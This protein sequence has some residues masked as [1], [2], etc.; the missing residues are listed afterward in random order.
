MSKRHRKCS[1]QKEI[2]LLTAIRFF[3][4]ADAIGVTSLRGQPEKTRGAVLEFLR[5]IDLSDVP[6]SAPAFTCW[7]NDRTECLR[8]RIWRRV[9]RE[10]RD[11]LKDK[12]P[13]PSM[14]MWGVA[15]KS[16]NLFLRC[17]LYNHY[18]RSKHH[19]ERIEPLLE[20]PLDSVVGKGLRRAQSLLE[21]HHSKKAKLLRSLLGLPRMVGKSHRDQSG[22]SGLPLWRH[23]QV[24]DGRDSERFQRYAASLAKKMRLP[25]PVFLDN[26]LWA[27]PQ[28]REILLKKRHRRRN[29]RW[30]G[31]QPRSRR[32]RVA[33][34]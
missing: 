28:I 34:P 7:L 31:D 3:A 26:Y 2:S 32:N 12:C 4:V 15:R 1:S 16:L 24:L 5:D 19:L 13:D 21:N 8:Q 9:S 14:P 27:C 11:K 23:L 6:R 30:R 10:R 33:K 22:D 25:A 29:R 20:V 18:L 17:C